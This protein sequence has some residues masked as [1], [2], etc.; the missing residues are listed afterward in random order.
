DEAFL[1]RHVHRDLPAPTVL[2]AAAAPHRERRD[3]ES[4]VRAVVDDVHLLQVQLR[5][6]RRA[7][8][9]PGE[10]LGPAL[11]A[12]RVVGAE[13]A[14]PEEL[15]RELPLRLRRF[16]SGE[17]ALRPLV[18][19]PRADGAAQPALAPDARDRPVVAG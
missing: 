10:V 18:G 11:V 8:A 9:E 4:Q 1:G 19:R 2:L 7:A 12:G 17:D 13:P 15:A 5:Q 3:P 16:E 6:T 14:E